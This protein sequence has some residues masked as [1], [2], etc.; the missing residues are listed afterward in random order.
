MQDFVMGEGA[1][2]NGLFSSEHKVNL[3]TNSSLLAIFIPLA[4]HY[5]WSKSHLCSKTNYENSHLACLKAWSTFICSP[6]FSASLIVYF[7][8]P[9]P[10]FSISLDWIYAFSLY[11]FSGYIFSST[12]LTLEWEYL[13][14]YLGLSIFLERACYF[15]FYWLLFIFISSIFF[16]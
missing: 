6:N 3:E 15:Y 9:S 4:T 7:L 12:T 10:S 2:K 8:P 1:S 14:D 11:L 13:I 5:Y 16:K